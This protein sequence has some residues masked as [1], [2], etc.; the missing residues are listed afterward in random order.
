MVYTHY[1]ALVFNVNTLYVVFFS[2]L[3]VFTWLQLLFSKVSVEAQYITF[4]VL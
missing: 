2:N 1:I 4:I 3:T